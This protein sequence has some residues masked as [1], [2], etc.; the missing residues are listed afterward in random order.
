MSKIPTTKIGKLTTFTDLKDGQ[1]F[2]FQGCYGFAVKIGDVRGEKRCF[3]IDSSDHTTR[4]P[5]E[6]VSNVHYSCDIYELPK[7]IAQ[8]IEALI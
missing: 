4:H 6:N 1:A 3:I 2:Y 5:G 7:S 8:C